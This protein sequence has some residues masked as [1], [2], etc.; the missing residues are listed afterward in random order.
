MLPEIL[1]T[2]PKVWQKLSKNNKFYFFHPFM[3]GGIHFLPV[4]NRYLH[5]SY[6]KSVVSEM[7]H[8]KSI[9]PD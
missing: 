6:I 4:I 2:T 9:S 7:L 8:W 5:D 3:R 1:L